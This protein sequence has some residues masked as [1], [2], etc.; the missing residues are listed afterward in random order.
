MEVPRLGVES[1]VQLPA[2]ATATAMQDLSYIFD[3]YHSSREHRI[4]DPLR[5]ARDGTHILMDPSQARY[6]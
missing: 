1:A 5:E 2:Y 6:C 3:L 4:L